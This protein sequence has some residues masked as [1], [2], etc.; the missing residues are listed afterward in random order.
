MKRPFIFQ[1]AAT[2]LSI[3]LCIWA[4]AALAAVLL[5]SQPAQ[6]ADCADF[7]VLDYFESRMETVRNG[8]SREVLISKPSYTLQDSQLVAPRP[9]ADG[10]GRV[11]LASGMASV[12]KKANSLLPMDTA[13]FTVDT[14]TLEG[15]PVL[16]YLD[17]TV[18]AVT[19]KQLIGDCVYTFSEVKIAHPS[20]LR[21]FFSDGRFGSPVLQTTTEMAQ[22]VNAVVASSGDYHGYRSIGIVVNDRQV[23]RSMGH[24]LDT[25]FVDD[26]GDL[27]F[28]YAGQITSKEEAEAF[29]NRHSLR[30]SLSFGPVLLLNGEYCVPERYNSGEIHVE[31]ARAAICQMDSLHYVLVTAN[32][33]APH[34]HVP[35]VRE[36]ALTLQQMGIPKAYALDGGQT[37]AIAMDGKL[38]NTVSYG[39]QRKISDIVYFATAV[40]DQ[41]LDS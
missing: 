24:L 38:I 5:R 9:D 8:A 17:E 28:A 11:S 15:A 16:Y 20:Q 41:D 10:Y 32:M 39:A 35:T 21:R 22:T 1:R 29:V 36:F 18:F 19:W 4:T 14:D 7:Q 2:A 3:L 34:Y 25:C 37:A 6:Q 23:H 12:L 26:N 31:Y 33:E 30:F 13:L 40:P 27:I